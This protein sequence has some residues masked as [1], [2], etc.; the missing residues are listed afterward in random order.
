MHPVIFQIG[1][2]KANS[3]GLMIAIGIFFA[4]FVAE[5][6]AEKAGVPKEKVFDLTIWCAV[7]GLLGAK[8]LF[9]ITEL[10]NLLSG[11]L[12]LK[13]VFF[14]FVVYGGIIGG[15]FSGWLFTRHS[16]L[17]FLKAFDL[18]MPSIALAQ[19]IGRIG[20]FLAGC[21]YG[22]ETDAWYGM[23]FRHSVYEN[24]REVKVIPTQLLS[25]AGDFLMFALLLLLAKNKKRDGIVAAGYLI[26][27]GVGRFLIEFLRDDPRGDVLGLSTSQFIS[28]PIVVAGAAF[29]AFCS[30]RKVS[31][32]GEN[33]GCK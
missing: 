23:T 6:R 4:E 29:M 25:S 2:F 17:D 21:C 20:C 27:Y 10:P 26:M 8:V 18:T 3:Y 5:K 15:I 7:G 22:K 31:G 13:D 11:E 12:S 16:K 19:G 9:L 30:L 33:N 24:M 32:K 1:G 14:G 28:I